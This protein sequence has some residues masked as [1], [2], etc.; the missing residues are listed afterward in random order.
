MKILF[1]S[2][3]RLCIAKQSLLEAWVVAT[4]PLRCERL[5]YS[6]QFAVEGLSKIKR[7]FHLLADTNE[8]YAEWERLVW[9]HRRLLVHL[10]EFGKIM[11]R[12]NRL[13]K[14]R[15]IKKILDE[16]GTVVGEEANYMRT[17]ERSTRSITQQRLVSTRR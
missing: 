17:H 4:R 12:K 10:C 3:N 7:L 8:I 13:N 1:R 9:T 11:L 14:L 5:G 16:N 6:A 2:G 15:E